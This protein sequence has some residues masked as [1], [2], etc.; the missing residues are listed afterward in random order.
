MNP[1]F[2]DLLRELS[3]AGV[4]FLVV[5]AYALAV[6]GLPRATG[7]IDIWV[8]ASETNAQAVLAALRAFGVPTS[9]IDVEELATPGKVFMLGRPPARVDI[10]TDIDGVAFDSAWGRR[11]EALFGEVS[12]FVI[13]AEDFITNK[14]STGRAKDFVDADA[15][16]SLLA[17]PDAESD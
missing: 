11:K 16:T 7:D 9:A 3:N 6:H 14:R 12:A 4:K 10:L 1:D 13:G 15:L 8:E 5:G 2:E 17:V